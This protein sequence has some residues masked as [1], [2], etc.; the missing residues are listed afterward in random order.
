M[1]YLI[2]FESSRWCGAPSYCVVEANSEVDAENRA[3]N[4]MEDFMLE[5]Y[6]DEDNELR[7]EDA[8]EDSAYSVISVEEFGP[9]HE[10]WKFYT[11]PEQ[12][13]F[14]PLVS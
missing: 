2:E 7:D 8:T 10:C 11:D 1:I 12:S 5:L 13:Q 9:T 14:F 3:S 6:W 4:Y